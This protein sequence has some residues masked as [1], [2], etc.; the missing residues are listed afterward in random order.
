[1][2]INNRFYVGG[3]LK[4]E[5]ETSFPFNVDEKINF[6]SPAGKVQFFIKWREPTITADGVTYDYVIEEVD[7]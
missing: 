1:M 7:R 5:I 6:E 4:L 2:T 3:V